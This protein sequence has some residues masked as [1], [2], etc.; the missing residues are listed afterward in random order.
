M[1]S[2]S[3]RE[4]ALS[5]YTVS[6]FKVTFKL[7]YKQQIIKE[8]LF[9]FVLQSY[10]LICISP[11]WTNVL[12]EPHVTYDKLNQQMLSLAPVTKETCRCW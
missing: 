5:I 12:N 10:V 1:N 11:V 8:A 2:R 6:S 9:L 7:S 3:L 4:S